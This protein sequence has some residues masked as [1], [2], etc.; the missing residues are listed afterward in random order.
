MNTKKR[1]NIAKRWETT[2]IKEE[3]ATIAS[4]AQDED[5]LFCLHSVF[6]RNENST[7]IPLTIDITFCKAKHKSTTDIQKH[8][9]LKKRK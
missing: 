2:I 5:V 7:T 3:T 1:Y 6:I 9:I 8:L 4:S